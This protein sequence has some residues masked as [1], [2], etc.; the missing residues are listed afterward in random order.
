[1]QRVKDTTPPA[2]RCTPAKVAAH[3]KATG[4]ISLGDHERLAGINTCNQAE[5]RSLWFKHQDLFGFPG[6][7][8]F[9][10]L[11]AAVSADCHAR[12]ARMVNRGLLSLV[13]VAA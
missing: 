13:Q 2:A 8:G 4:A 9:D 1:M 11:W 3:L 7:A 10:K 6:K 12:T 5:R